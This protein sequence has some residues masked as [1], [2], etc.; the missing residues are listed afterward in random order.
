MSAG[1][2]EGAQSCDRCPIQF[3]SQLDY[4]LSEK[5]GEATAPVA[6]ILFEML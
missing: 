6:M 1:A 4:A 3:E 2:N 5:S